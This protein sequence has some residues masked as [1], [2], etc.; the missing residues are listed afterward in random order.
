ML[1]S[2][3]NRNFPFYYLINQQLKREYVYLL[4]HGSHYHTFFDVRA[5][6]EMVEEW[7]S[8]IVKSSRPEVFCKKGLRPATLLKKRLWHRCI[9]VNFEKFLRARF[10]KEHLPVAVSSSFY[11]YLFQ[12]IKIIMKHEKRP[13]HLFN[14]FTYQNSHLITSF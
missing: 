9:P 10:L 12:W 13:Q 7:K 6:T 2:R 8:D 1:L 14:K 3:S 4:S 5:Q 11:Q